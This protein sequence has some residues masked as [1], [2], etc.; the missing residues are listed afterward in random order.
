MIRTGIKECDV[1]CVTS[2]IAMDGK[3]MAKDYSKSRPPTDRTR[4]WKNKTKTDYCTVTGY[5][6]F[7][8]EFQND[9]KTSILQIRSK[10]GTLHSCDHRRRVL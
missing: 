8:Y 10:Q 2:D 3:D 1:A 5:V 7:K 9:N 6:F 4:L